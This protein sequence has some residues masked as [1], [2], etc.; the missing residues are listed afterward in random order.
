MN[1]RTHSQARGASRR[2]YRTVSAAVA[3]ALVLAACGGGSSDGAADDSSGDPVSSDTGTV[4][5]GA[6]DAD[7]PVTSLGFDQ[8]CASQVGFSGAAEYDASAPGPHPVVMF[9]TNGDD[10]GFFSSAATLPAGWELETDDDFDD[11]SDL[12]AAQLVSCLSV[13]EQVPTGI[14]CD[15][16]SEDDDGNVEIVTLE[17]VDVTYEMKIY[18]ARTGEL[19]GTETIAAIDASCPTFTFLDEGQ[20]Q[21]LNREDEADTV[22][23]LKSYVSPDTADSAGG[24]AGGAAGGEAGELPNFE[25]DFDRICNTQVGFSGATP[26]SSGPGPRPVVLMQ[27]TDG[28]LFI[29]SSADLPEGWALET[30]DDFE[31]NSDLAPAELVACSRIAERSPN[32]TSCDFETDD[33]EVTSLALVD[34]TYQLDVYEAATGALVGSSSIDAASTDCPSFLLISEGDTEELNTPS[35]DDYVAALSPFV[36]PG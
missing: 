7:L 3:T 9:R 14:M 35:A 36:L 15:L 10:V 28:G 16:E 19:V 25:S 20:T 5:G 24:S 30:D 31:D 27:E 21:Y 33:G 18:A 12:A 11:N 17:V 8:V 1:Q 26:L 22:N 2:S 23:A 29:T 4:D 34:V 13:V 6:V 32:G